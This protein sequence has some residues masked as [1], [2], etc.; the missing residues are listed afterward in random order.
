MGYIEKKKKKK[1]KKVKFKY[2]LKKKKK[3]WR[4]FWG[5]EPGSYAPV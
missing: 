5:W 4:K 1:K 2:I 3:I